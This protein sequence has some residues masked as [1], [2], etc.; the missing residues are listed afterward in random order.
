MLR[1]HPVRA[2]V[3]LALVAAAIVVRF[4]APAAG[5]GHHAGFDWLTNGLYIFDFAILAL[6]V[7]WLAAPWLRDTLR[8]NHAKVKTDI[9][10]AKAAFDQAEGRFSAAEARLKNLSA[11][12]DSLMAEFRQLGQAERDSLAHE[13]AVLS[14]KIREET[15]FRLSQAVK[16]ARAELTEVVVRRA[17]DHVEG[18]MGLQARGTVPDALVDEVVRG[19]T[20]EAPGS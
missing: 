18:R 12:V 10:L 8:D 16:M 3:L 14:E 20:K 17:F 19:V 1:R 2:A 5:E 9:D 13:G 7:Y 11:E 15:D 4:V 6:P